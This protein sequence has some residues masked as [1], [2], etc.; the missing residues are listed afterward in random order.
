M[1]PV[2]DGEPNNRNARENNIVELIQNIVVN[3]SAAEEA[4]PTKHPDRNHIEHVFV[5][6]VR[7]K[8]SVSAV[9]FATVAKQQ[10][11]KHLKLTN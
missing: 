5:K 2:K 9:S 8:V 3:S 11:L 10:R 6:H 4:D 1:F 7:D